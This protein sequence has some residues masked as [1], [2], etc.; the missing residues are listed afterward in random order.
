MK[1]R[2]SNGK[3]RMIDRD[4]CTNGLYKCVTCNEI[5]KVYSVDGDVEFCPKCASSGIEG[6]EDEED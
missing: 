4:L 2:V 5:F 3:E 1:L 6:I